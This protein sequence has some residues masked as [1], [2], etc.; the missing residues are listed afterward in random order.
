MP[1]WIKQLNCTVNSV[2]L[3][4]FCSKWA[5]LAPR[6]LIFSIAPGAAYSFELNSIEALWSFLK[7][8]IFLQEHKQSFIEYIYNIET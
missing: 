3:A 6:I 4:H 1:F 8:M 2:H 5:G 7:V